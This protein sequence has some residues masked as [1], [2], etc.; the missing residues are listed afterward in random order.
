VTS[1]KQKTKHIRVRRSKNQ[2]TPQY[3][4]IKLSSIEHRSTFGIKIF[5]LLLAICLGIVGSFVGIVTATVCISLLEKIFQVRYAPDWLVGGV[6]L[7]AICCMCATSPLLRHFCYYL[8]QAHLRNTGITAEATV[9]GYKWSTSRG[10]EQI[11]L[12]VV[13]QDPVT[14]QIYTYERHYTFFWELFSE[15]KSV[16]FNDYYTGAYLPL[17]FH[18]EHPRYF[19]LEIP[20]VPCWYDVLW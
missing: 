14:S 16:M 11:D 19:A 6:F 15:K 3:T 4:S 20:F 17:I 12:L 5:G 9:V 2:Q 18:P 13:W 8:K 1:F 10:P 7:L